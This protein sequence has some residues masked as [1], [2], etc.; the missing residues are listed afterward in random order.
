MYFVILS[1]HVFNVLTIYEIFNLYSTFGSISRLSFIEA[2]LQYSAHQAHFL[3]SLK[4]GFA[5]H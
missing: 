2:R 3:F 5:H 1:G 4:K